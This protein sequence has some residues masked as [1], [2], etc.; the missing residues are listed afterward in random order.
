MPVRC[1][2]LLAVAVSTA[3]CG[4]L[5]DVSGGV[6]GN[7]F[8]EPE[9]GEDCDGAGRG[10]TQCR[11]PGEVGECRLDCSDDPAAC[12]APMGCGSDA[13][14]RSP[15]GLLAPQASLVTGEPLRQLGVGDLDG[16]GRSELVGTG[17]RGV[18]IH[19]FDSNISVDASFANA[20]V[21]SSDLPAVVG[22]LS[23]DSLD[24]VVL[25][26][27]LGFVVRLG[28]SDRADEVTAHEAA[29]LPPIVENPGVLLVDVLPELPGVEALVVGT[30]S[31]VSGVAYFDVSSGV[32]GQVQLLTLLPASFE[33]VITPVLVGQLDEAAASPC[34]EIVI[35]YEDASELSTF[36]PCRLGAAGIELNLQGA[37]RTLTLPPG[38]VATESTALLDLNA[39]GHL[40]VA[41]C[42]RFGQVHE[43]VVGYGVG[44]GSFHSQAPPPA[45]LG[46]DQLAVAAEVGPLPA[47]AIGDLNGDGAVDWV[48]PTGVQ[49]GSGSVFVNPGADF[50]QAA[51][52]RF[53]ATGGADVAAIRGNEITFITAAGDGSFTGHTL[54]AKGPVGR[55]AVGDFDGDLIDDL[56]L[57]AAVAEGVDALSIGFGPPAG[58]PAELTGVGQLD[59]VTQIV[60]GRTANDGVVDGASDMAVL[61]RAPEAGFGIAL[62]A[63]TSTRALR[64]PFGYSLFDAD[65]ATVTVHLPE[66]AVIAELDGDGHHDVVA[67]TTALGKSD[68]LRL[69]L[70]IA[71]DQARLHADETLG[72][73][74]LAPDVDWRRTELLPADLD[75]DGIDEIVLL[76]PTLDG[77]RGR[78]GVARSVENESGRRELSLEPLAELDVALCFDPADVEP[79]GAVA[80][81]FD[82]DQAV[83]VVALGRRAGEPV[84]VA[85]WNESGHLADPVVLAAPPA[86][87]PRSMA[88]SVAGKLPRIVVLA[89]SSVQTL[90]FSSR[91]PVLEPLDGVA[92]PEA[93]RIASADFDG[94]G[95]PDVA[96]AS[97]SG[98]VVQRTIPVHD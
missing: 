26:S 20:E 62:I 35:A 68:E 97:A 27:G 12:P 17:P 69:F 67:L 86:G 15:S 92:S 66:R 58:A 80:A 2:A 63:G 45:Q 9:A 85:F 93:T 76:G 52:A 44:D 36:S 21:A 84:L 70:A 54:M 43:I 56:T 59:P 60:V 55:I 24:D 5:R 1:W 14:C 39:D 23:G 38:R 4:E 78:I 61:S 98:V 25:A 51:I 73:E 13:I 31:G 77:T 94:D 46:D 88:L 16:D 6:C 83:D 72:T 71:R 50:T 96:L 49:V 75:G 48:S 22:E 30:L 28:A 18:E 95:V 34:E 81:D 29:T 82:G 7:G 8:V 74:P 90:R 33:E 65:T 87:P 57:T 91:E 79:C 37:T 64:A 42:A 53:N 89:G 41:A 3:A 47:L 10:S 40:D 19:Y 11:A 32:Q